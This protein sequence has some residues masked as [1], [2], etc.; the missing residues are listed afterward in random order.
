M[1]M[2]LLKK[3]RDHIVAHPEE[4]NQGT[5][6]EKVGCGTVACAAGWTVLLGD[7]RVRKV[8]ELNKDLDDLNEACALVT[9]QSVDERAT[10]LLGMGSWITYI[11]F[12][13]SFTRSG[14]LAVIDKLIETEGL[15]SPSKLEHIVSAIEGH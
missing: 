11:L 6:G 5:W 12:Y 9:D 13:G 3:V 1:N 8:F 15:V 14:A 7:E 2:E 10:E 4:H